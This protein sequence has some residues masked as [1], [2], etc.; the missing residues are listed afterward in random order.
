MRRS[1]SAQAAARER[2]VSGRRAD[3]KKERRLKLTWKLIKLSAIVVAAGFLIG[4]GG[5]LGLFLYHGSDPNLPKVA[6]I[7]DFRPLQVT[8]L[9]SRKGHVIGEI[10][11]Q[12]RTVVEMK[13]IPEVLVQATVAAE[14]ARFF[15]HE[16]LDKMGMLRAFF[17]N[18]KAG[19][20]VQGGSTITQQLVK[21]LF[22]SPERTMKRKIQELILA[23]RLEQSLSKEE[24]LALYLNQICYGHGRYG[25][26]EASRYYFGKD[27]GELELAEAAL[28]A[29]LPQ[30]PAHL[31]PVNHP[32]AAAKRRSYVLRRMAELGFISKEAASKI[33]S[34]P[35]E[36]VKDAYPHMGACPEITDQVKRLLE[37][38]FGKKALWRLGLRVVTSCDVKKQKAA[39]RA[40]AEEMSRL[41]RRQI[42]RVRRYPKERWPRIYAY[43][44]KHRD[45]PPEPGKVARALVLKP[46]EDGGAI[47]G[48]TERMRARLLAVGRDG[49]KRKKKR[50][51]LRSGMVLSVRLL[52]EK[53]GDLPAARWVGPEVAL[54]S[55][56]PD[57]RFVRAM[58]GG[59]TFGPGKFN[60]AIFSRRQ[61]GSAFKPVLYGTALASRKFTP[62]TLL[63]DAPEVFKLWKPTNAGRKEYLGPVRL[64]RALAHSINTVAIKL[65]AE[66]G[67]DEVREMARRL[68]I[69]SRLTRDLSL[70]L[71]SSGV[72]VLEL[73]NAFGVFAAHGVY[74]PPRFIVSISGQKS[75]ERREKKQVLDPAVAYV[76][77][78][79]LESVVQQG[80]GRRARRLKRPVAGKTGTTNKSRDAW[81]VGYTARLVTGVWVGYDD[82]KRPLGRGE[83]GGRTALPVWLRYMKR[84]LRGEPAEGFSQPSNVVVKRIDPDTGLLAPPSATKAIEEVFV[85]GTAPTEV[86][87]TE[88]EVE[89]AELLLQ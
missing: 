18:L 78:S 16:G 74:E 2:K 10:Y 11:R 37:T 15:E 25:V 80:T 7:K 28:L 4:G 1:Y 69:R 88:A 89:P 52:K 84:A 17:A 51:V 9:L 23:R 75:D 12:R 61:P 24:I 47:L 3:E 29:G 21:T 48:L 73:T 79:M 39:E 53:K 22:L 33:S 82:F 65:M 66:V 63:P 76:L 56:E 35:V 26:Q 41:D 36:V 77:T 50:G 19:R 31:S 57:T 60:R 8:R 32:K 6:G 83:S 13:D 72:T 81:F 68:G 71:G 86:A 58:V 40:V 45:S 64:R 5:L 30:S 70:A 34:Q 43:W 44:K 38:R 14:D 46:L 27:V 20:Y 59:R 54:V 67:V 42:A 85:E 62:A 55:I 49:G 87:P